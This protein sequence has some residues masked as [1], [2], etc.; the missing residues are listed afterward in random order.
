VLS[1]IVSVQGAWQAE[2]DAVNEAAR[3]QQELLILKD[4]AET[5]KLSWA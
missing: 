3:A 1:A 2:T 4:V 5:P